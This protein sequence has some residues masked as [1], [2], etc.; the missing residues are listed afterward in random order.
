MVNLDGCIDKLGRYLLDPDC[1]DNI[2]LGGPLWLLWHG[3]W[4]AALRAY[5]P[6][7]ILWGAAFGVF[8][9]G[10]SHQIKVLALLGNAGMIVGIPVGFVINIWLFR[11]WHKRP[12]GAGRHFV[13]PLLWGIG[14]FLLLNGSIWLG[15]I[16]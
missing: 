16:L 14:V 11:Y 3:Q 5:M 4:R 2:I 15:A 7:T 9:Y 10:W 6:L 8:S 13:P 1:N 12:A